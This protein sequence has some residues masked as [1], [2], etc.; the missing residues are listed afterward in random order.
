MLYYFQYFKS[1]IFLCSSFLLYFAIIYNDLYSS[2]SCLCCVELVVHSISLQLFFNVYDLLIYCFCFVFDV[3]F[4]FFL[5]N[6]S[7]ICFS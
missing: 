2:I 1:V 4:L 5:F 7:H 6:I 3:F